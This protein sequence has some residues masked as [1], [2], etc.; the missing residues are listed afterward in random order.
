[1]AS[2]REET[3]DRLNSL[4]RGEISAA[5]TYGQA[6]SKFERHPETPRLQRLREDHVE[7]ANLLRRHVTGRG[8]EN[9]TSSGPW[10]AFA[11]A[12]EGTAKAFGE[13]AALAALKEGEEHGVKEYESA[14]RDEDLDRSAR[15]L[16]T[17]RLLPRQ[18]AHID[19]IDRL[20]ESR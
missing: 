6:L 16:I 8:E 4:L 10:G 12:V 1:M 18:R 13:S 9:A 11:K 2:D 14:L 3:A 5:E 20:L 17:S 19:E 15:E 7:A